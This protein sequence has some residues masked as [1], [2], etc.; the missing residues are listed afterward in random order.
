MRFSP[1]WL[2]VKLQ[3]QQLLP[4]DATQLNYC[5][6]PGFEDHLACSDAL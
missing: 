2:L 4:S 3:H 1:K 6:A 5:L